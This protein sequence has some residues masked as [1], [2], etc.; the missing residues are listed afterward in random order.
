MTLKIL[1]LSSILTTLV[2]ADTIT[3]RG[4]Q[5]Y[6]GTITAITDQSVFL[7]IG[8]E[9]LVFQRKAIEQVTFTKSDLLVLTSGDTLSGKIL[10]K[11]PTGLAVALESGLREI[12]ASAILQLHYL[13]GPELRLTDIE[14]TDEAFQFEKMPLVVKRSPIFISAN[15]GIQ[16][17]SYSFAGN[18][19]VGPPAYNKSI[20]GWPHGVELGVEISPVMTIAGGAY[21]FKAKT[22]ITIVGGGMTPPDDISYS[23][24]YL[25]SSYK[26]FP[27]ERVNPFLKIKL[28]LQDSQSSFDEGKTKITLV[29]GAGLTY[30][31]TL[32][33]Q[34]Y[35]EFDVQF[36]KFAINT[37]GDSVDIGGILVLAGVRVQLPITL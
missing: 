4:G 30:V 18:P 10:H 31:P 20:S 15:L 29:P 1:V 21:W 35:A 11:I 25:S 23:S 17:V 28:A 12:G 3:I 22:N 19:Y 33:F 36:A 7:R 16:S 2:F 32:L 26:F 37:N 5:S 34:I 24:I 13:T 14:A 9:T 27:E 8:K 6:K